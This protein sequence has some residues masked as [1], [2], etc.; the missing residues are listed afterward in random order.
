LSNIRSVLVDGGTAI[1]LVP[2]GKWNFGTLDEVLGHQRRYTKK[3]LQNLA[4]E[5]GF[6][7]K[8]IVEFN[9]VGTPAWF[10]NGKILHRRVFGLFQ[11]W[12]LN[13]LTPVF[14]WLD[15][16][17]P[18][19]GLSLIAVLQREVPAREALLD[20]AFVGQN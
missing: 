6:S 17:L 10:V 3:C 7:V 4:E 20:R 12:F 9:R 8:A 19:P 13:F 15:P 14:R 16:I 18:F 2:Q 5:C 11:I 1:I